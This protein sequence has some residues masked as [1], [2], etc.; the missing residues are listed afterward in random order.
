MATTNPSQLFLLADHIKLSLL[1]RQR[2]KSLKLP[3]QP[4]Q[5]NQISRSLDTLQSGIDALEAQ[6]DDDGSAAST[7]PTPER[8]QLDQLREQ[9]AKLERQFKSTTAVKSGDLEPNDP[10]LKK[11]FAAAKQV[12]S[13]ENARNKLFPAQY[14]DDPNEEQFADQT[15]D[16]SNTQIHEFHQNVIARQDEQLDTLGQSIGRTRELTIAIGNELDDHAVL[17]DEVDDRM[18][19]HQSQ[20]DG[21]RK[22]LDTFAKKAKQNWGLSTIF[23]LIV[24][25]ILLIAITK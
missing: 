17:L 11:D 20:L 24:V 12:S 22:R 15:T 4:S 14:H 3:A 7:R 13:S 10:F 5:D 1:E 25:L 18:D 8:D 2:A 21:A 16:M 6:L 23:I 19:R 9:Y